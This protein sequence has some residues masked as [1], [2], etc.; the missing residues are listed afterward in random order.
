[1]SCNLEATEFVSVVELTESK[2]IALVFLLEFSSIVNLDIVPLS[3]KFLIL[4]LIADSDNPSSF[5]ISTNDFLESNRKISKI[6]WSNS[7]SL[8]ITPLLLFT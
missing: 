5:Q 1:M 6:R 3:I 8:D 7:L 4:R 2:V